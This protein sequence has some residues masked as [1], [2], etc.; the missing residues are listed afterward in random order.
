MYHC[1]DHK[2]CYTKYFSACHLLHMHRQAA[3][4]FNKNL[5]RFNAYFMFYI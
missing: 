5:P 1:L 2:H 4:N 3:I